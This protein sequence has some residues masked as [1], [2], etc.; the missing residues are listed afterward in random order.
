MRPQWTLRVLLLAATDLDV[1]KA[2]KNGDRDAWA[3]DA[4]KLPDMGW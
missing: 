1:L 2:V 4:S 3:P